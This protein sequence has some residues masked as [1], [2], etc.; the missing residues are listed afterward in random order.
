MGASTIVVAREDLSIPGT[1]DTGNGVA[2][3]AA[4]AFNQRRTETDPDPF[5]DEMA[6]AVKDAL[7]FF[8]KRSR[9]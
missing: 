5:G 6:Q 4:V 1:A 3:S 2:K 7:A 8:E 9:L